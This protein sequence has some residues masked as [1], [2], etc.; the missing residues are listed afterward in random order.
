MVKSIDAS[1]YGT[2]NLTSPLFITKLYENTNVCAGVG[3]PFTCDM[4]FGST[5]FIPIDY[6]F[7][8]NL[9][10]ILKNVPVDPTKTYTI[11]LIYRQPTTVFY[12]TTVKCTDTSGTFI[13]GTPTTF[14]TPVFNGGT[15]VSTIT[16]NLIVQSF[17]I[18][19]IAN[20]SSIF[21]RF[22]SSSVNIY[23]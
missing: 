12:A 6:V 4:S 7:T 2:I 8:A 15:A 3:S 13:L 14:A 20:S 22:V 1:L 18:V 23:Y 17:S 19:S 16:P 5:F 10:V 21:S 9:K 11:S